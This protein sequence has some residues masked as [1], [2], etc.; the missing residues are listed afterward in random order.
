MTQH[1][2]AVTATVVV[3]FWLIA[4]VLVIAAHGIE[5]RSAAAS[6]VVTIVVLLATAWAYMRCF[7]GH[8]DVT[9]ALGVGIVWLVLSIAVEVALATRLGHG[10][11]SLLGSPSHP[12]LRNVML[13][14]WIFA[15]AF[16]AQ[17]GAEQS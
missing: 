7:A 17:G 2:P 6:A 11:F 5:P 10:W 16:F 9:H 13:F 15:P 12:L 4:A 14:V 1:R 8:C 3:L